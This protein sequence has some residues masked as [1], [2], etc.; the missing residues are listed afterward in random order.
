MEERIGQQ[1][2]S[3]RLVHLLGQGGF[4]D[5][6]LGEH[7]HLQTLAAVK[8]LQMRLV[9]SNLEPFRNEARTI[10]SLIH[11]HIVRVLDFGVEDEVPFLVMEYAPHG[12][13]R[14]TYPKGT[15][16]SPVHVIPYVN[17]IADALYYA[18]SRKLMHRDIKPENILLGADGKVLLSDFGLVQAVQNTTSQTTK[19]MAGT[20]AYMAP[21]QINGKPRPASDQYA[22][23]VVVYEWLSGVRP[24][25]GSLFEIAT[26]HM[27]STPC[28][29]YGN[30]PG[31]SH[32]VE[33]VIF[34]ALAKDPQQRF[35]TVKD[36]ARA[37]EQVSRATQES[38]PALPTVIL[39]PSSFL[40]P[41]N[42]AL[43]SA[44]S[45]LGVSQPKVTNDTPGHQ[46][47][48]ASLN[49]TP[50]ISTPQASIP[51]RVDPTQQAMQVNTPP[52]SEGPL[53]FIN[54]PQGQSLRPA[55]GSEFPSQSARSNYGNH[56]YSQSMQP[57]SVN[58][59]SDHKPT[60]QEIE[61]LQ[62]TFVPPMA[63]P[64][65]SMGQ[66]AKGPFPAIIPSTLPSH[67]DSIPAIVPSTLFSHSK[68]GKQRWIILTLVLL[69][70]VVAGMVVYAL[71]KE[72]AAP[73]ASN[74]P[75]L[76][77]HGS[78]PGRNKVTD[79]LPVAVLPGFAAISITAT[80]KDVKNVF[81]ISAVTG[82]PD[83]SQSQ[84]Q[85]RQVTA[86]QSQSQTTTATGSKQVPA[87]RATGTLAVTCRA[88]SPPLTINAG[89]VFT[90][91]DKVSVATDTTVTTSGCH[92]TIP[93]HAVNPGQSGNI[94][95]ND[96]NQPYQGYNVLNE[97]AFSGGQ[98]AKTTTVVAQSDI[99]TSTS[100]LEAAL[101][102]AVKQALPGKL[103]A[104]ERS[105]GDSQC[106]PAVTPDHAAGDEAAKVT[107]TVTMSCTIEAYDNDA[108]QAMAKKLLSNQAAHD[109]G[110]DYGLMGNITT[111]VGQPTLVDT[112]HGT[113]SLPVTTEGIWIYQWSD[114]QKQ[115][116]A[117][118]VAG[119][120][121]QDA[122]LLL[123]EKKGVSAVNIQLSS[124][125]SG[126][127]P[128]EASHIRVDVAP[129]S[130][131]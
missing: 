82:M 123:V 76:V 50:M 58:I 8:V 54:S 55:S 56:P 16:L 86:S 120:S 46:Q 17:Q 38:V 118:L 109:L 22:L 107:V 77:G 116:L 47:Q 124:G 40:S 121:T 41:F 114:A 7:I 27:I 4:A 3:Y 93:T 15:R 73:S 36:F 106:S 96:V 52:Q 108:A 129:V 42:T 125:S 80:S 85:A 39:P 68:S 37:F 35:P 31:I 101:T 111:A 28:S 57:T 95:A 48:N 115:D 25:H 2:G 59:T 34:S 88:S 91:N 127:L 32:E 65:G 112:A 5:V 131:L 10:A 20:I 81:T 83:S 78:P 9:G 63:T 1:L 26:Q 87:T 98:D 97:A 126:M 103:N 49:T 119:R 61:T 53:P 105:F 110:S 66:P 44:A 19:E 75:S 21:E 11:P 100:S 90:G 122:K 84:V 12:T 64:A 30:V 104:N 99:D 79:H 43:M 60:V 62:R 45:Q 29:L 102:P 14:Q 128:P 94:A 74:Q 71:S 33:A 113:L 23:G 13:L 24:F 6:Y 130:G 72:P 92:T 69:I 18:H 70:L 117:K 89:T 67:P 51:T